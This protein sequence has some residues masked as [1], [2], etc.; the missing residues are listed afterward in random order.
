LIVLGWPAN[1][2]H[3]ETTNRKDNDM[4]RN[5]K[6]LGLAL[7]VVFAFAAISASAASA[8]T[9][10]TKIHGALQTTPDSTANITGTELGGNHKFTIAGI[11]TWECEESEFHGHI[12]GKTT[13]PTI[14]PT[15]TKCSME[16]F[17]VK[18]PSTIT[19]NECTFTLTA[20]HFLD[21]EDTKGTGQIHI[22][23][24]AGKKI[25]IHV[26]NDAAHTE[27]RCTYAIEPQT[28]NT[29]ISFH[30]TAVGSNGKKVVDT[31]TTKAPTKTKKLSGTV[32]Q[33]GGSEFNS[34]YTGTTEFHARNAAGE[35]VD[36]EVVTDT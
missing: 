20:H 15:Y 17:G 32:L 6:A 26:F 18:R 31:I 33:C 9:T 19:H 10:E 13:S 35:P 12:A 8:E 2:S 27:L 23:C 29:G 21:A 1:Q 14:T 30:N 22:V 28:I 36:L 7:V 5:L 4:T 24:P 3:F 11:G 34:E 16:V 25:E